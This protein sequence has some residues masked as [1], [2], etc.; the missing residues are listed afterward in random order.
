MKVIKSRKRT[1]KG[2]GGSD[3][4]GFNLHRLPQTNSEIYSASQDRRRRSA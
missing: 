3:V 1:F 2:N 4:S